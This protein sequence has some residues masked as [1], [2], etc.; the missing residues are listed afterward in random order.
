MT[1]AISASI[2]KSMKQYVKGTDEYNQ[3]RREL[4][5]ARVESK[6]TK[7]YHEKLAVVF[8][9]QEREIISEYKKRYGSKGIETKAKFPLLNIAKWTMIYEKV[10]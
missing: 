6:R 1:K 10:L 5:I 9:S 2:D 4:K 8:K 3:K 7:K